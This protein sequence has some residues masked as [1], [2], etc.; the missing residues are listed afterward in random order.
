[1]KD[2][3]VI[4]VAQ[5]INHMNYFRRVHR[6]RVLHGEVDEENDIIEQKDNWLDTQ[7]EKI[8]YLL[9][10]WEVAPKLCFVHKKY[11]T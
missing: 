1:M 7:I 6:V 4:V 3:G 10:V 8:I 5:W 2:T 9:I 11:S